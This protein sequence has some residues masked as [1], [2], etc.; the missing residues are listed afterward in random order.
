MIYFFYAAELVVGGW[1][2]SKGGG[3][4]AI[5][6]PAVSARRCWARSPQHKLH[7]ALPAVVIDTACR[8]TFEVPCT[9]SAHTH[10]SDC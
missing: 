6:K 3:G 7:E 10:V 2:P 9:F 4:C 8:E 5:S 1:G